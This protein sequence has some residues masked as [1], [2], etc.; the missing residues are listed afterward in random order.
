MSETLLEA[1]VK[2]H[3]LENDFNC[4]ETMIQACNDTF[5]LD[6]PESAYKMLSGFGNG[7]YTG[8]LCRTLVGCTCAL[9]CMLVETRA[10]TT[11]H[12]PYAQRLLVRNFRNLL[13]NTQ[14]AKLKAVHHSKE[15]RCLTTCLLA[16]KA[17]NQT[18]DQLQEE[19]L[20]KLEYEFANQDA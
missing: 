20:L 4:A 7:L 12:L 13:G 2:H 14:C 1:N 15:K 17:M 5:H 10:H 9:S 11:E 8:N 16:A 19:G 18:L 3:Y 6:L